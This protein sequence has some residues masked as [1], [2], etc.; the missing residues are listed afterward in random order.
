MCP[1]IVGVSL[2]SALHVGRRTQ[3]RDRP[4]A[5]DVRM[6]GQ[7]SALKGSEV[8]D[9]R[10]SQHEDVWESSRQGSRT[11]R[12]DRPRAP[13]P[14]RAGSANADTGVRAL[15]AHAWARASGHPPCRAGPGFGPAMRDPLIAEHSEQT[16]HMHRRQGGRH[17]QASCFVFEKANVADRPTRHRGMPTST[18]VEE[19]SGQTGGNK[20][21]QG[22]KNKSR[23]LLLQGCL[24]C[25]A[26]AELG[27]NSNFHELVE[28][29]KTNKYSWAM[30][31]RRQL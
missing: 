23:Q 21:T 8:D 29:G 28:R 14:L 22:R 7:T 9:K 20:A 4:G 24:R 10:C 19:R 2:R 13:Q 25:A 30:W 15:T 12:P 27:R 5:S 17:R 16:T 3:L 6:C 31:R 1:H 18:I 26:L 11:A